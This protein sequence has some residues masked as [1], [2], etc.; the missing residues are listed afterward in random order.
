[1]KRIFCLLFS[2]ILFLQSCDKPSSTSGNIASNNENKNVEFQPESNSTLIT[3]T[4]ATF[5]VPA[6][7]HLFHREGKENQKIQLGILLS[8]RNTDPFFPIEVKEI[9]YYDSKGKSI[10]KLI[11]KKI[12]IDAMSTEEYY[13]P[14]N[15]LSGGAGANFIVRLDHEKDSND[16]LIQTVMIS[17]KSNQGISFVCDG[18][19]IK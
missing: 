11:Q 2:T 13:I 10:K 5:Y 18:I 17:T 9:T 12:T 14:E 3:P 6:Y 1:M 7:G 8:I 19:K 16:P 4:E 15:D